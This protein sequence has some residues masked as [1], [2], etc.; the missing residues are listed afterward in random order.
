LVTLALPALA[1]AVPHILAGPAQ[2]GPPPEAAPASP[3]E[4][5]IVVASADTTVRSWQPDANYGAEHALQTLY[6]AIDPPAMEAAAL[7]QFG[8]GSLPVDAVID[9]ATLEL[10]LW[11]ANGADPV[12]LGVYLITSAW[13][14]GAMTW[15][16]PLTIEPMGLSWPVSAVTGEYRSRDVTSW[17]QY[18]QA[19]RRDNHGLLIRAPS[20]AYSDRVFEAR[21]HNERPPRLVLRYH[22]PAPPTGTPTATVTPAPQPSPTPTATATSRP[23]LTRTPTPAASNTATATPTAASSPTR[24][25]TAPPTTT[26]TRTPTPTATLPPGCP[27]VLVNGD[28]ETGSLPPWGADGPVWLGSGRASEKGAWL[29]GADD[30]QAELWQAVSIPAGTGPVRL[31][32][33][34]RADA[35]SAQREDVLSVLVQAGERPELLGE[36]RATAPLSQWRYV[37]F[38][39]SRYAGRR[40]AVT[41]LARTDGAVPTTFRVDDVAVRAC[42]LPTVTP[43]PTPT[44]TAAPV[45]ITFEENIP[46][47]GVVR[48]QYCN[49]PATNKGV[50]FLDAGRIYT[51][52]APAGYPG[53]AFTNRFPGEE[54][55]ATKTIRVRFTAGQKRVGVKVGLDRPY[56]FPITAVLHTYS[57]P[58]PGTGYLNFDTRYLGYGPAA[59]SEVLE[60]YAASGNIRSA[61]IEFTSSFPNGRGDEVIDDLTFTSAGPPCIIDGTAPQVQIKTP[62]VNGMVFQSPAYPLGFTASDEAS[63]VARVGVAYLDAVGNTLSAYDFCGGAGMPCAYDVYPYTVSYKVQTLMPAGT[64]I[65]RVRAWDFAGNQGQAD[66]SV[67][68]IN[69]GYFN[70]WAQAMEVTQATQPWLP[71]NNLTALTGAPPTHAYPAAPMAVPL[72]ANRLTAARLYAGVQGTTGNIALDNVRAVLRCYRNAAYTLPCPGYLSVNPQS[73]PP[74]GSQITIRPGDSL[75]ARRADNTLSWNFILPASW[76]QAGTIY[77]ESE[78]LPPY[79]LQECAGCTDGANRF[80]IAAI[81]FDPVPDFTSLVHFV[82]IRRTLNGVASEPTQAQMDAHVAFLRPQYPAAESTLPT[83]PDAT[84]SWADCGNNCDSD[85]Q[86][87]L[88]ARCNRLWSD[89]KGAFPTKAGKLAVYAIV[90]NGFPCAGVG[91]GGYSYG[92]ANR[93][94]SFPHEVGH[95]V[96]LNHCGPPPGHGSVCPPPGGGNCAECN[97][98]SWCDTDWPWPHGTMGTSYGLDP[99]KLTVYQPGTSETDTHDF[100]S[101]GGP[102][103]WVSSRTWIRIYNAFT[104]K[105]L[106][107]PAKTGTAGEGAAPAANSSAGA[108]ASG[109]SL[110]ASGEQTAGGAWR[111]RPAFRMDLPPAASPAGAGEYSLAILD[112]AGTELAVRRFDLPSVHADLGDRSALPL[113]L[114]FA[115]TLP[116]SDAAQR[117][118]LRRGSETLGALQRSRNSPAVAI[119]SPTAA[120]FESGPAG[121]RIR[122]TASDADGDALAYAVQ[123]RRN[124]AYPWRTLA[125]GWSASELPVEPTSLPGGSKAQVRV[126]ASDGLNTGEAVSAA[127]SLPDK[128]PAVAIL[129]AAGEFAVAAGD[130][131]ML[132]G[133][134]SDFEDGPLPDNALAWRSDRDGPLGAG[135]RLDLSWLSIGGHR[136]TLTGQDSAGGTGS[137]QV[138]VEV[139]APDN[140]QPVAVAKVAGGPRCR[141]VLDGSGSSDPD[142]DR[143]VYLWSFASGP[144]GSSAWLASPDSAATTFQ[145]NLPGEYRFALVVTDGAVA[146]EPVSVTVRVPAAPAWPDCRYLP[147]GQR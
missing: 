101:Y 40:A 65:V 17:A 124:D 33:W 55:S 136:I 132:E 51:P 20:S 3:Q 7:V 30:T 46:N 63:G 10:Y 125:S 62:A 141:P 37:E 83:V 18:W 139:T 73:V 127:F 103:Q 50:E 60:V 28:F 36:L 22:L 25:P 42:G 70:L 74:A 69:I 90:D 120:G 102:T 107:Y 27:S 110:L 84:W 85:P 78:V 93:A 95:A 119:L 45:V 140:H 134:G 99:F 137:A 104:G 29:A 98:A 9:Q 142:G 23:T 79:G 122:W 44:P 43:T 38:E 129:S 54:F 39:L 19:H 106:P 67:T 8:L 113:P 108:A 116:W 81:P 126:L 24:T 1:L 11:D 15:N 68:F 91:G 123:V 121:P 32:L 115:E 48:T 117:L 49:N 34:W 109:P 94:D 6:S 118:V 130:L 71:V 56:P 135:R 41:F 14:E 88:N 96:G 57:D 2:Q 66:R 31:Q 128:P 21:E 133:S 53:H 16:S 77:L 100:M 61:V 72:V 145:A 131:L 26:R 86:K 12:T 144:E 87:N 105:K 146:S 97:P 92:G 5:L 64:K 59:V 13:S 112:R 82:R 35:A 52:P 111:L 4:Q 138:A 114:S 147:L 75:E 143:L 47:P 76:T 80:R 58:N 89:L